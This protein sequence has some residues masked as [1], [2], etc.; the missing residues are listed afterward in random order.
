MASGSANSAIASVTKLRPLCRSI[1]PVV[2]RGALKSALSPTVASMRPKTIMSSA[3]TTRPRP[4][5]AAMADRPTSISAKY[6][7]D[8]NRMATHD[9]AGANMNR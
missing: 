4:A 2:K 6:S 9:S 7:A 5:N 1:R 3:L 8:Q